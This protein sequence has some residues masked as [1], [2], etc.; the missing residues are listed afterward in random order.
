M[1]R[2]FLKSTG[3]RLAPAIDKNY[4]LDSRRPSTTQ[5]LF[6]LMRIG[7]LFFF[8][9]EHAVAI[10][11]KIRV[12]DLV[13]KFLAHTLVFGSSLKA[14]RAVT[15]GLLQ[16]FLYGIDDF[17]VFIQTDFHGVASQSS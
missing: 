4:L 17:F 9:I 1:I 6:R 13:T 5:A 14:A 2:T 3:S 11:F 16:T 12:S 8:V 15:A 10:A 7:A